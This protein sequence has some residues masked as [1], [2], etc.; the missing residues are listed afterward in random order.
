MYMTLSDGKYHSRGST[1]EYGII[2]SKQEIMGEAARL[3]GWAE[4][5]LKDHAV[6]VSAYSLLKE[7]VFTLIL[8]TS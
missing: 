6:Y 1:K 8:A 2:F 3:L 7:L 4:V 5:P